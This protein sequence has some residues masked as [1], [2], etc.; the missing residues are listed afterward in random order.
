MLGVNSD[1]VELHFALGN[2]FRRR[3]EMDRAIRIHQ[4][5]IARPGLS[6]IQR[7]QALL[8]LGQDYL[9]AGLLDRAE[10][11]FNELVEMDQLVDKALRHLIVI[12]QHEKDWEKCLEASRKLER[13]GDKDQCHEQAHYY[14]E[15]AAEVRQ[16]GD[17]ERD[18]GAAT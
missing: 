4:N 17:L 13:L 10:G 6:R 1:T 5:L 12:F 16:T 3:G 9:R 2:L 18:G 8:E 15:L 7:A 11:L 14:C